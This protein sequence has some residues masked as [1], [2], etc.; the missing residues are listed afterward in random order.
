MLK[1]SPLPVTGSR[2]FHQFLYSFWRFVPP[3]PFQGRLHQWVHDA[4]PIPIVP[5]LSV[6]LSAAN[7]FHP[8]LCVETLVDP[9]TSIRACFTAQLMGVTWGP[10]PCT[11]SLWSPGAAPAPLLPRV[12]CKVSV[13]SV[14][15]P[16][17]T[18]RLVQGCLSTAGCSPQTSER[19][20]HHLAPRFQ[21]VKRLVHV[22]MS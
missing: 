4:F 3:L 19:D 13:G 20:W 12:L 6:A 8:L 9:P 11:S 16:G 14:S 7:P 18:E 1:R 17:C 15:V 22:I 21:V 5:Y 10:G 2:I